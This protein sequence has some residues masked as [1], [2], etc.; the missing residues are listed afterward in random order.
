[1]ALRSTTCRGPGDRAT[2]SH[3][4]ERLAFR[5]RRDVSGFEVWGAGQSDLGQFGALLIEFSRVKVRCIGRFSRCHG[6]SR[7][8]RPLF[9]AAILK[10]CDIREL[11][12]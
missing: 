1:M 6:L 12:G 7:A 4:L 2:D 10:S 11:Q 8:C 3:G 9:R 5:R